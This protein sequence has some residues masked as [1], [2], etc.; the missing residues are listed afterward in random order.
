MN[1][2]RVPGEVV[3]GLSAAAALL[4]AAVAVVLLRSPVREARNRRLA[5]VVAL[6]GILALTFGATV[7]VHDLA[8]LPDDSLP[9]SIV[10]GF[11]ALSVLAGPFLYLRFLATLDTPVT[12]PL[13]KG[14]W[15][16]TARAA[17]TLLLAAL[18]VGRTW[19]V[20]A[21]AMLVPTFGLLAAWT[22]RQRSPPGSPERR[23]A[24]A[25]LLAFG[26]RDAG[27]IL[28][29]AGDL[30]GLSDLAP[31]GATPLWYA[32]LPASLAA[33]GALAA[34]GILRTQL[35]DIDLKVKW[36][37]QQGVV[38]VVLL[39]PALA[40]L[41]ALAGKYLDRNV[42]PYLAAAVG[43]AIP[44]VIRPLE[45]VGKRVADRAMPDVTSTPEY[46]AFK[47][48]EVYKSALETALADGA[49]TADERAIL[50]RV[51]R[52]LALLPEDADRLEEE[53][54]AEMAGSRSSPPDVG[55]AAG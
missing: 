21:W 12:E 47:K 19:L 41:T 42:G 54:R 38:G 31:G 51:R 32:V 16:W 14:R 18:A 17:L 50:D 26:A 49:I 45:H 35:F 24:D 15:A 27:F 13:R 5:Q 40:V 6:D 20:G 34:Y 28:F 25:F 11:T 3:L 36:T 48:R 4:M 53:A 33:F 29:T 10:L 52:K 44:F 46:L 43:A 8:R 9:A 55:E 37:L 7:V 23:R 22:L 1:V 2:E 39:A 30:L